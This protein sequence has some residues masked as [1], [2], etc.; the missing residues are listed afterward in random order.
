[1]SAV[2]VLAAA[3]ALPGAPSEPNVTGP[4]PV[5][6]PYTK[7]VLENGLTLIVHED[8]KAPIVA[9]N[10]W[11]HVGS[12]NERPGKTGFAHLFEHLMFNGS[13]NYNS[14][15][16][17]P[18][19]R[20]GA[21]DMNGTTDSD[22]TNYFGNVPVNALDLALFMESDRMGHLLGVIDQ[23]RLD[24]QRGVV[25]NEK[26]QYENQPYGRVFDVLTNQSYPEG[27][28]YSWSTIGS[29]DDLDA[30][31]L[32]DVRHWFE[33]YYGAANAVV[34]VAGAVDPQDVLARVTR[35]FGD[36]PAG[37]PMDR[38]QEWIAAR[39]SEQRISIEDRVPQGR[40]IFAWNTPGLGSTE[41]DH[42]DLLST[43]LGQGKTS[44][45]YK[46]LVY[47][48][49]IAT[50]VVAFVWPREIAG[51]FVVWATAAPGIDLARVEAALDEELRAFFERGP[52]SA[53]LAVAQVQHRAAFLRG[54]ERIG[55]F[56]GKSDILASSQV[57]GG[58]PDAWKETAARLE[59]ATP[60][61]LDEATQRWLSDGRLV[62][63]VRPYP[64]Y[65]TSASDVDR[66]QLP[67][68]SEP[69]KADFPTLQRTTLSNGLQ[70]ILAERHAVP[71]VN[72]ELLV[73]AGYA[74]DQFASEGTASLALAMLDEG[75]ATRDALEIGL[76]LAA[77]G[78]QL[79]TGSNLDLSSVSLS[80]LVEN[81]D[82]S[83]E[84]FA[85]VVLNPAF[86]AEEFGR[87]KEQQLASIQR[88]KVTP[89]SMALR[90]FP[91]LLYGDGHAYG[92][93]FTGSGTEES[94]RGITPE[95]LKRF[96]EIWF[97]PNRAV[98]V[99]VGDT[100]LAEIQP[101]LER[102]FVGWQ[103][104]EA[105]A[106]NVAQVEMPPASAVYLIDR[107]DS[108]Q[109]IL[110]AGHLA[111]PKANPNEIAIEAMN[112]VL[113]GSFSARINMNLREDKHWAYGASSFLVDAQGQRPFIVYA[114]VQTDKT[115]ESMR[116]IQKELTQIL[117]ERPPTETERDR[118][119]DKKTLTLP[120]RFESSAAVEQAVA[121]MVRFGF[122]DDYWETYPD[123]MRS[124][125]VA[126][127]VRAATEVLHPD[128][129]TWVVVGD[130][131]KIEAGI[132]AANFG[133]IHFVDA[134]GRMLAAPAGKNP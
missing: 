82:A 103:P 53:E 108:V 110:F 27:H 64:T 80:A 78:A 22:R 33:T 11:Y 87:L 118:A 4:A 20:V 48:E 71:V 109:S 7:F 31:S 104:G 69:P 12:K 93:S 10:V 123:R 36:I 128:R 50:D 51:M 99:I 127:I 111:P 70:L 6:I 79:E 105:P 8:H 91:R 73:D 41:G 24:E 133:P 66:S 2:S 90:V 35:W 9:V 14:D 76:E 28:P 65:S 30:A 101:R 121:E 120:G 130:R 19:D 75:T 102:L 15:Y 17:G 92:I 113:G 57:Y 97:R 117:G 95:E 52:T 40:V 68:A 63:E 34:V 44:P 29:M 47:Q 26:R 115:V 62:L 72:F 84:L 25:Q 39:R 131:S 59:S 125:T 3:C 37:P 60:K 38:Q 67:G 32:E 112:E 134:D 49:R 13:E 23:A 122:P 106:K 21:T 107:P 81:L 1:V 98:L 43:I 132:R 56:G 129:L 74:A 45:L 5:D 89:Q 86:D 94:V 114:P 85:D 124:Q 100:T 58:S 126:T 83:L 61:D 119:V 46:R 18:F 88:E 116:E 42:L 16:F 77:L 96:H 55:G 54:I